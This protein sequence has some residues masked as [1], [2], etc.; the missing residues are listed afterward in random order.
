MGIESINTGL[1]V[2]KLA[3]AP[4]EDVDDAAEE[5]NLIL[6]ETAQALID[7]TSESVLLRSMERR[8]RW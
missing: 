3:M 1:S 6:F 2:D 7:R 4:N 5:C 8:A